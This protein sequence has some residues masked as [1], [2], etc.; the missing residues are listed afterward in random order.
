MSYDQFFESPEGI[1]AFREL[2]QQLSEGPLPVLN[3]NCTYSG[4]GPE[5]VRFI[6][7]DGGPDRMEYT[8][9]RPAG[10]EERIAR[11]VVELLR[12]EREREEIMAEYRRLTRGG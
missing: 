6:T 2:A 9:A 5:R 4:D 7:G 12:E 1:A 10:P 11:R 3:G 8:P